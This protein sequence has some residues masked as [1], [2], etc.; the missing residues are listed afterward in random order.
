MNMKML[1]A[2]ILTTQ[3]AHTL[4]SQDSTRYKVDELLKGYQQL[5]KFNGSVL[6]TEKGK[7]LLEEGYG[8]KNFKDSS[9][10]DPNTVFQIAS[11]TKQFTAVMILKLVE[12]KKLALTDKLIQFFPE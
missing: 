2:I 8:F 3:F 9:L 10:N 1:F 4:F 12:L 6:V 5:G 11:V 7:I